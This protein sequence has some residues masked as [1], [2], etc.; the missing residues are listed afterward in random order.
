MTVID[1]DEARALR[2]IA[3]QALAEGRT[4]AET[5]LDIAL[6]LFS[7]DIPGKI[8][9]LIHWDKVDAEIERLKG[10]GL[11]DRFDFPELT[12]VH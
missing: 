9:P 7:E 2:A 5:R 6:A 10:L 8:A 12:T 1:L 4:A 11:V 3:A